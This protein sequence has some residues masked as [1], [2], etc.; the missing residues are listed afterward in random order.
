MAKPILVVEHEEAVLSALTRA[1]EKAGLSVVVARDRAAAL[2]RFAEIKPAAVM[3]AVELAGSGGNEICSAIRARRDGTGVP[4]LFLGT[5]ASKDRIRST[6]EALGVGGDYFF[7]RPLDWSYLAER[8]RSWTKSDQPSATPNA[9]NEAITDFEAPESPLETTPALVE[10]ADAVTAHAEAT[11]PGP[12]GRKSAP[13]DDTALALIGLGEEMLSR[14]ERAS[15]VDAFEAAAGMYVSVQRIDEALGMFKRVLE[16]DPA[17]R[18]I[19]SRAAQLAM[20]SGRPREAL[21][22]Y[23]IGVAQLETQGD[24]FDAS[25]M[26]RRMIAIDPQDPAIRIRLERIE[27]R[28]M[29]QTAEVS[30]AQLHA[31]QAA[32][33]AAEASAAASAAS[34]AKRTADEDDTGPDLPAIEVEESEEELEE[35]EPIET[36]E[37]PGEKTPAETSA[38]ALAELDAELAALAGPAQSEMLIAEMLAAADEA[39]MLAPFDDE[40]ELPSIAPQPWAPVLSWGDAVEQQA[41]I[42]EIA[43]DPAATT[44]DDLVAAP[45]DPAR[46]VTRDDLA[47]SPQ[48][49]I[50]R[51]DLPAYEP[52]GAQ[53]LIA[54]VVAPAASDQPI[55][56]LIAIAEADNAATDE[57]PLPE[58]APIEASAAVTVDE[59][60]PVAPLESPPAIAQEETVPIAPL[61]STTPVREA[62]DEPLSQD[63]PPPAHLLIAH[64]EPAPAESP[65]NT[66]PLPEAPPL[67]ALIETHDAIEAH[68]EPLPRADAPHLAHAHA[69]LHRRA[70]DLA[71]QPL[72]PPQGTLR[73]LA[74]AL[75]LCLHLETQ[76]TTGVLHL[77][78]PRDPQTAAALVFAD[79]QLAALRDAR[80]AQTLLST[81]TKL[82]RVPET[83]LADLLSAAESDRPRDLCRLLLARNL[84]REPECSAV[85]ERRLDGALLALLQHRGTWSFVQEGLDRAELFPSAS[86]RDLRSRLIEL[87]PRAAK[88]AELYALIGGPRTVIRALEGIE[89]IA[90]PNDARFLALLDGRYALEDAIE[91]AGVP[92]DRAIAATIAYTLFGLAA[93]ID[94]I[95]AGSLFD[96]VRPAIDPQPVEP[97]DTLPI[98]ELDP[99]VP[100]PATPASRPPQTAREASLRPPMRPSTYPRAWISEADRSDRERDLRAYAEIVRTSDYFTILGVDRNAPSEAIAAAHRRLRRSLRAEDFQK[101]PELYGIARE[102]LRSIDEAWDVLSVPELRSAYQQHLKPH[103][104]H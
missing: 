39:T 15:A 57:A 79:G 53:P 101:N 83:T 97:A 60:I 4:I 37:G 55:E 99:P 9:P 28:L 95:T 77:H 23:G 70:I 27:H 25:E 74:D 87:L 29:N 81:F 14:G 54:A 86:A 93:R 102:V 98:P 35:L 89:L 42:E 33:A 17:R 76:R 67:E 40:P 58:L 50:T 8:V 75:I 103:T 2:E 71:A 34:G 61:E 5:G 38:Q 45:G 68:A 91:L 80:T 92:V 64:A 52:E 104:R 78:A 13:Q 46:E 56:E 10:W 19:V 65:P 47:I 6:G 43:P 3:I 16:I 84:L 88:L 31:V 51:D 90:A 7:R 18:D 63:L 73:A 94:R 66:P 100:E 21:V 82:G 62:T 49:A 36:L 41:P 72:I 22:F 30:L 1:L 12:L 96:R 24:L 32:A 44:R 20:T 26:C 69:D 85:L 59:H 48:H 11:S